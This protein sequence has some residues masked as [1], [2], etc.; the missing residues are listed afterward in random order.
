MLKILLFVSAFFL[1]YNP[2]TA[3][4]ADYTV[5]DTNRINQFLE[6]AKAYIVK[7]GEQ[8]AD[9]DK[10][11]S[12]V[13]EAMLL[14]TAIPYDKGQ[15][16]AL[17]LLAQVYREK[18]DLERG[19]TFLQRAI[20]VFTRNKDWKALGESYLALSRN[21]DLTGQE[22]QKRIQLV[23]KAQLIFQGK[24][25]KHEADCLKELGDLHQSMGDYNQALNEL[26]QALTLYQSV[27]YRQ[28]Q[29]VYGLLGATSASAG[30][31]KEGIRYGLLAI[32][33][34]ET[35]N[36]STLQMSTLYNQLGISYYELKE[37]VKA[38]TYFRRALTIAGKHHDANTVH[39]LALN[40]TNS[41]LRLN[42]PK[43]ALV[44][45]RDIT[46]RY[47]PINIDNRVRVMASFVTIYGTLKPYSLGQRYCNQ[48]VTLV[49]R[50]ELGEELQR[51]AYLSLIKFYFATK[52]YALAQK[53][54]KAHRAIAEQTQLRAGLM[55]SHLWA[56][57]LDSAQ[58]NYLSAI[59]QYQQ[60]KAL[61][62]SLVDESKS[63]QIN[64]LEIRFETEKK[65]KDIKLKEK[66]IQ[67]LVKQSQI[68]QA[69]LQQATFTRNITLTGV[70]LLC[71]IVGLLY[72]GYRLKQK[73]N[74]QL[75]AQQTVI[76]QKNTALQQLLERQNKLLQEKEWLM[77]EV[78]HRVK[79]NL[80][81]VMSLLN[82]QSAYQENPAAVGAIRYMQQ[83]MQAI[84]L[85]HQRLYQS[86]NV[87]AV[88]MAGYVPE[89]INYLKR[90][91][92]VDHQI[93]FDLRIDPIQL[94]VNQ[95]VPLSL[96]LNEAIT[97]AIKYAFPNQQEAQINLTLKR[98]EPKS[99]LLSVADNG[100]G[101]PPDFDVSETNSLGFSLMEGFCQQLDGHF[102]V[103]NDN[104]VNIS[105]VFAEEELI[106]KEV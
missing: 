28:L 45:L 49:T 68:Q 81:V 76:H 82:V 92:D 8:A 46:E 2:L 30:D 50:H 63:R 6:T 74:Q 18:G 95:A 79:N 7:P 71:A 38:D 5:A 21:Y 52:Q 32:Q 75:Q 78:H 98:I 83:R 77:K 44:F 105:V 34:G 51:V 36:D 55:I 48:L 25:P 39:V 58:G 86:E 103:E 10:A 93:V 11:L 56:F 20:A 57:R 88:D 62:D 69:Q 13:Q 29:G 54:L 33:T 84:S 104:G 97:N 24:S 12:L 73:S 72:K 15:G 47:A 70:A 17:R 1:P 53:Y 9:L 22:L 61:G 27:H 42:Q 100:V 26:K 40:I 85:I 19:K 3:Q 4:S 106:I 35:L 60:F 67:L 23:R 66:N 89:F 91:F 14:S 94:N 59:T 65:N 101:L 64:Q 41:L 96:L 31:L 99:I 16:N 102:T 37:Y 43:K 80:Q 90:V 87:A